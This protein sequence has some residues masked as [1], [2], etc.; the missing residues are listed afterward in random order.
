MILQKTHPDSR[1][2]YPASDIQYCSELVMYLHLAQLRRISSNPELYGDFL[3]CD[4]GYFTRHKR[5]TSG[6][7]IAAPATTSM[8]V[9]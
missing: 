3:L 8:C 5:K 4:L 9:C 7:D 2:R 6:M 1:E